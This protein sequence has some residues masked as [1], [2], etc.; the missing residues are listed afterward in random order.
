MKVVIFCGGLGTRLREETEFRPK[1]MVPVGERPILWHIMKTYAHYGHKEFI[2]CL[3]YKGDVIKEYFRN[4]HWNT[5]DVTLRLGP[6]PH[7]KYHNQHDEE[8]WSVTLVDTGLS[9]MTGGRLKRVLRFI[10]EDNFLVTYGDGLTNSNINDSIAFHQAQ[11]KIV[12][13]TAVRPAGRFGDLEIT[14]NT[15]TAFKEKA[16]QQTGF[17]NGGFFVMN[18]RIGEVLTDDK[19]VLEQ[20]P[21]NQL[22]SKGQI[23]AFCHTGFWQC[24]DTYRE[25]QLLTNMWTSGA[26]PWKIW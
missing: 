25:Q 24:M 9:T 26:A 15:V 3:G 1:P 8:D 11:Q 20:E 21:L 4:Y 7:I 2:L 5:S 16:E 12:T 14:D 22:A 6:R 18:K 23:A 10:E 13:I 17:I 19:C